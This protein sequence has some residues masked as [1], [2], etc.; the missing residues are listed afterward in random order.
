[1]WI[2]VSVRFL[3]QNNKTSLPPAK[4]KMN[5]NA[6]ITLTFK[7]SKSISLGAQLHPAEA[8]ARI[9]V[10]KKR[11]RVPVAVAGGVEKQG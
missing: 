4:G 8:V 3:A 7:F 5:R 9:K 10:S 6:Y 2:T 11:S 1:M